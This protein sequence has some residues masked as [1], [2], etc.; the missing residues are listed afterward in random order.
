MPVDTC[1]NAMSFLLSILP[2]IVDNKPLADHLRTTFAVGRYWATYTSTRDDGVS[3]GKAPAISTQAPYFK[4]GGGFNPDYWEFYVG[5]ADEAAV[6]QAA[7]QLKHIR[8]RG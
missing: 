6:L 4:A 1:T 3:E 2:Q 8:I 7:P 5:P